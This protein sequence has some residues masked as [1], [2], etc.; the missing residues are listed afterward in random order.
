M[1]HQVAMRVAEGACLL[2]RKHPDRREWPKY[3]ESEKDLLAQIRR[4]AGQCESIRNAAGEERPNLALLSSTPN[5]GEE[6]GLMILVWKSEIA[7]RVRRAEA[8]AH[9]KANAERQHARSKEKLAQF[10][11][12][13]KRAA[14]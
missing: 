5:G 9:E 7:T 14:A 1:L 11:L 6:L 12:I 8:E 13:L 10:K 2:D 4:L 3:I